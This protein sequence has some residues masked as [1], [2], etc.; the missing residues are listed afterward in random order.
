MLSN[1]LTFAYPQR[2]EW[3]LPDEVDANTGEILV[4]RHN[5]NGPAVIT[6]HGYQAWYLYGKRHRV[7]GPAIKFEDF[8]VYYHEG[9]RHRLD[10]PAMS[11]SD[12]TKQ[13]WVDGVRTK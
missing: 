7:G 12:G 13:W 4:I 5:E 11:F 3:R 8:E 2:E 10:G 1:R 6:T 9:K